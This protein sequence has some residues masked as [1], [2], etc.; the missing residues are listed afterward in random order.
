MGFLEVG[1]RFFVIGDVAVD[2][3]YFL[4]HIPSPGEE[5]NPIRSTMQPGGAGGTIA[6]TLARLGHEVILAARVGDD[7]FAEVALQFVR[8]SGV[9]ESAIQLD[10]ELLTSTIT[11]LQTRD[12]QRAM[13]AS[14]GANRNLDSAKLKKRDVELAQALVVSAYSLMGGPQKEY[15]L[16]AIGYAKKALVPVFI[17]LGAGAV[18]VAGPK[19]LDSI[20][21]ADYLLLNQREL[22]AIAG[23][24]N[25]SDALEDL[26]SRGIQHVVI[27]VGAM[28][29][30]VWTPEHTE[31]IEAIS[32]GE[33][34]V[35]STGAG[36]TF[37]AAFAQAVLSGESPIQAARLANA[38][39]AL[40]STQVGSQA[41]HISLADLKR[42][43]SAAG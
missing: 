21:G 18:N 8:E 37:S 1:L 3:L 38:A 15:A 19:L 27:K 4:H 11:V 35:D 17:D 32:L 31:L 14:G 30:I 23:Q 28:G 7:P 43:V 26:A 40:A 16:K 13:I 24:S 33:D 36:D 29:S 2:H 34:I 39:G 20:L 10:T 5:V 25:I 22:L 12:G 9:N 42:I 6:V 41:R